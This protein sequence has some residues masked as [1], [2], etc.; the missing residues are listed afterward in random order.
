MVPSISVCE[1][2]VLPKT[3]L[4]PVLKKVRSQKGIDSVERTKLTEENYLE[5]V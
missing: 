4:S 1:Q 2:L 5:R 3:V